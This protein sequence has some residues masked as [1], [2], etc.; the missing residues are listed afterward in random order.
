MKKHP[1]N[2][3]KPAPA[4]SGTPRFPFLRE[5]LRDYLRPEA[6]AEYRSP[7]GVLNQYRKDSGADAADTLSREWAEVM[8]RLRGCSLDE[9]NVAITEG[10]G[11]VWEFG[12]ES[13]LRA[14]TKKMAERS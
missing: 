11:G 7:E 3:S 2:S 1:S 14:F 13:E 12:S 4:K 10:L 6:V 5:F 8:T 9:I